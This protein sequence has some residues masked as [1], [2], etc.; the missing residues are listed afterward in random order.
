MRRFLLALLATVTLG[1]FTP[2]PVPTTRV[3]DQVGILSQATTMTLDRELAALEAKNGSQVLVYVTKSTG[4]V[5]LEDWTHTTA[6][7]WKVGQKKDNNGAVLFVFMGDHKIRLEVGTGL[8]GAIPD[9]RAIDITDNCA[10][11]F[12]K[13]DFNGGVLTA[14]RDIIKL[15]SGEK[16]SPHHGS[17]AGLSD[18][19]AAELIGILALIVLFIIFGCFFGFG[20]VFSFCLG[21]MLGESF[22]GSGKSSGGG[23]SSGGGGFS[24]GGSSSDF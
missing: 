12:K 13:G 24:G 3:T 2:P 19:N 17:I 16:F 15:A 21:M 18:K 23:F 6:R 4:G 8:E 20:D 11:L 9:T 7:A 1:A 14:T 22:G 5:P 10:S